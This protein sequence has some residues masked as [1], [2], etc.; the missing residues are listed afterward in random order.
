MSDGQLR[1]AIKKAAQRFLAHP[2]APQTLVLTGIMGVG[3]TAIGRRLAVV[4]R[5]RFVDSDQ[6]IERAAGMKITEI[7]DRFGEAHFRDRERAVI[8]R[9]LQDNIGVIAIGGGAFID[10]QTRQA[11]L[12][13]ALAV[14]LRAPLAV[15]VERTAKRNTRPLL[16]TGDPK[17]ILSDLL[18]KRKQAYAQAQIHAN[19]SLGRLDRT[20]LSVLNKANKHLY[21]PGQ[22]PH[23]RG[24]YRPSKP[25]ALK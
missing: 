25:S 17:I 13:G 16:K 6:E 8:I 7:F 5:Q 1:T 9:L 2:D 21:G 23:H 11:I 22:F 12:D 10:A 18:E 14:W 19:S 3:K 15:L 4:L 20:V 24:G